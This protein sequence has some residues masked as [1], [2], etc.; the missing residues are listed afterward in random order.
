LAMVTEQ[1]REKK[2]GKGKLRNEESVAVLIPTVRFVD[3]MQQKISKNGEN[4][5]KKMRNLDGTQ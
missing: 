1:E 2:I 4:A 5:R 3:K